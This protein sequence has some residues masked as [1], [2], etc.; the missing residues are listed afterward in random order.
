LPLFIFIKRLLAYYKL[1]ADCV[2]YLR[3]SLPCQAVHY[4][5]MR[6]MAMELMRMKIKDEKN[7]RTYDFY[8]PVCNAFDAGKSITRA[9]GRGLGPGNQDFFGPCEMASSRQASAV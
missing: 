5:E 2:Q 4:K 7:L 3:N 9:S 8:G 6:L 1:P